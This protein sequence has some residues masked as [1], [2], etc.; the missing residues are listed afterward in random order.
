MGTLAKVLTMFRLKEIVAALFPLVAI[1]GCAGVVRGAEPYEA[2]LQKHCVRCHGPEK[3]KGELRLDQLSRDFKAGADA[4]RWAEVVEKINSGEMPPK[5]EPKPTRDEIGA[6]VTAIDTRIKEGRAARMAARPAV[7][8]YRLSRKEYQNTVYDLLG[9]RYDPAKPGELNED[10]LWHGFERIGSEL[11]LSPSHVDRYYRAAGTVLDRAFGSVS[12][13][14]RKVRKTAADLRYGGGKAAQ[15]ALDR[16]KI[17]RPLRS[18][19]FP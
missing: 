15:E 12:T 16:F 6:F 1:V 3:K 17:K 13:E 9:V 18:L 14:A 2:F 11:S 4:Q 19:L 8:H 10:T 5:Q 7:A